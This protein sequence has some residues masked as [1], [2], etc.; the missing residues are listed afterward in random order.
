MLK[1]LRQLK[2]AWRLFFLG[3]ALLPFLF[4]HLL[5]LTMPHLKPAST[6]VSYNGGQEKPLVKILIRQLG[7]KAQ[8]FDSR[9]PDP[10]PAGF[11]SAGRESSPALSG[12][13]RSGFFHP[14][15]SSPSPSGFSIPLRI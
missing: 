6:T 3:A 7:S 10:F 12:G 15:F 1:R 4:R 2:N 11:Y 14:L 9:I 5:V 8:E 13:L